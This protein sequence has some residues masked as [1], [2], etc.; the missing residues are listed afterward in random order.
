M[1][2]KSGKINKIVPISKFFS[3]LIW[4]MELSGWQMAMALTLLIP[5][6]LNCNI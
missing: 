2:E 6:P 5:I 3:L 4:R 1:D